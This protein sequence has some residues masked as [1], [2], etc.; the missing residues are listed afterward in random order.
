ML[1]LD[2]RIPQDQHKNRLRSTST[3]QLN[4]TL[5]ELQRDGYEIVS[6]V[7][8]GSALVECIH[9]K[10]TDI[11]TMTPSMPRWEVFFRGGPDPAV[12][13]PAPEPM[14]APPAT[15]S[16]GEGKTCGEEITPFTRLEV[17]QRHNALL[18]EL[19]T[20]ARQDIK[21]LEDD[22]KDYCRQI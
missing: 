1:P 12:P 8:T 11:T 13:T 19:L 18:A 15:M 20:Q 21:R 3:A 10:R 22:R 2:P 9:D 6:Y 5:N 14:P 4:A 16:C 7:L 17:A